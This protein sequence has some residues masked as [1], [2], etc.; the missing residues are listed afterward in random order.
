MH[1]M[2]ATALLV[3]CGLVLVVDGQSSAAND[4]NRVPCY[5]DRGRAQRCFPPF[6]NAA[7]NVPVVATNTC[8]QRGPEEYCQQTGISGATKS[9]DVC[10]EQDQAKAHPAKYLTDFHS[11]DNL[12]WWQSGTMMS[13]VQWPRMVNLTLGLGQYNL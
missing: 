6:V 11:I 13:D 9:C 8:G 5:G 1:R 3:L 12:S 7:F 10:N 2:A 4:R